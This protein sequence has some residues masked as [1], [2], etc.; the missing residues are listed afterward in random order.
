MP[1][2]L[3]NLNPRWFWPILFMFVIFNASGQGSVA[4][5]GIVN[6]DKFGHF[7]VFGLL[8]ILIARTQPKRRWWL[9][10]VLASLYGICDEWRQSFT[11]GRSVELADWVADTLGAALAVFLYARWGYFR[12]T[13]ERKISLRS[14]VSV[15][16]P[17]E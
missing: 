3:S 12:N 14:D 16:K 8:G 6:I 17:V 10:W 1:K 15:A 4:A 5:P 7:M 9:G 2:S 13:L 11:P